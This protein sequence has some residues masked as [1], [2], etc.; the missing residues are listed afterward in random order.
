[1]AVENARDDM[2]LICNRDGQ[3]T[4]PTTEHGRDLVVFR[5]EKTDAER[6]DGKAAHRAPMSKRLWLRRLHAVVGVVASLNLLLLLGTGFLL[7]H[8]ETFALDEDFVSRS[9]LPASYRVQD[10][11][12][13][14]RADIVV[15]DLHSGRLLGTTGALVLDGITLGW[16]VLLLSGLYLFVIS[17]GRKENGLIRSGNERG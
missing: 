8:R 17:R 1:M 11:P 6:A 3:Q 9:F 10:G 4:S 16:F 15:T 7:Q 12:E 5:R 2:Q 13:G 14:V